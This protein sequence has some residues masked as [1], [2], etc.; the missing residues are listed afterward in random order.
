[1]KAKFVVNAKFLEA[2]EKD[3]NGIFRYER[4]I[5]LRLKEYDKDIRFLCSRN[6]ESNKFSKALQPETFGRFKGSL[7]E[8]AD[9]PFYVRRKY[10]G[11]YILNL[12]NTSPVFYQKKICAIHDLTWK[13]FPQTFD[14]KSKLYLSN[15]MSRAIRTA[16]VLLT[17]SNFSKQDIVNCYKVDPDKIKVIYPGFYHTL[18]KDDDREWQEKV[19]E[20]GLKRNR[21]FLATMYKNP[22]TLIKA[23]RMLDIPDVKLVFFG[24]LFKDVFGHLMPEIEASENIVYLGKV[25]DSLL[26]HLYSNALAF[27]FPTFNEGFGTPPLE[28]MSFD[29]P[30][31]VSNVASIPEVSGP[32]ALY[33]DPYSPSDIMEKMKRL[34]HEPELREELIRKGRTRFPL[35]NYDKTTSELISLLKSLNIY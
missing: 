14:R 11:Y 16:P 27:V 29:C 22:E 25:S 6:I 1:M 10:K 9:L 20:F 13:H 3:N 12:N 35:F 15:V 32:A 28:A 30:A 7:W 21:F 4:E 33:I 23:F 8:Q 5:A 31:I 2:S 18:V 17:V 24:N 26:I 34:Y 19:A